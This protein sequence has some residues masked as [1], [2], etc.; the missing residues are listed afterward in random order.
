[1]I[2]QFDDIFLWRRKNI[3]LFKIIEYHEYRGYKSYKNALFNK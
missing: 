3:E 2:C 1:M